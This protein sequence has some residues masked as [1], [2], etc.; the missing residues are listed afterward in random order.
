[1]RLSADDV[2][3]LVWLDL[4]RQATARTFF[5]SGPDRFVIDVAAAR[6]EMPRGPFGQGAGQGVVRAYRFAPRPDGVSRLVLDL[7]SPLSLVRQEL[8]TRRAPQL[9]F[10]LG[11]VTPVAFRPAQ[12]LEID[13]PARSSRRRVIVV[14]PGHG[15]HDPGAIGA[16]GLQ[17]KD[18]VLDRP[19]SRHGGRHPGLPRTARNHQPLGAVCRIGHPPLGAGLAPS[20]VIAP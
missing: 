11:S 9:S 18:V 15:G 6:W 8:G 20:G 16:S 12:P 3:A 17:E 2:S 4:D 19:A 10:G 1:M 13:T 14:D 7:N 5:L